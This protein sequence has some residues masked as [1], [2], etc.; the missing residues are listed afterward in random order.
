MAREREPLVGEQRLDAFVGHLGPLELEEQQLGADLRRALLDRLHARAARGIGRVGREV[1]AGVAPGPADEVGDL[2]E[3][4]HELG[5]AV[6]VELGDRVRASSRA[7]RRGRRP[8]SSSCVETVVAGR[9][10]QRREIP[11]DVGGG[12][13]GV[14]QWSCGGGYPDAAR[15]VRACGA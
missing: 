9:G 12:E 11:D 6:G 4:V 2:G 15:P 8:R 14:G 1:E 5:E 3:P 10:Q 13:V 7:R